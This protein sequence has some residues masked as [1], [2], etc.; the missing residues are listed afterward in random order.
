MTKNLYYEYRKWNFFWGFFLDQQNEV[1]SVMEEFN[2]KGW[3]VRDFEWGSFPKLTLLQLIKVIIVTIITLGF[4]SYWVGFSI[5][6]ESTNVNPNEKMTSTNAQQYN[7]GNGDSTSILNEMKSFGIINE[8]EYNE[9]INS[10]EINKKLNKHLNSI[11]DILNRAKTQGVLS[12]SDYNEKMNKIVSEE[13]AKLK[14]WQKIKPVISDIPPDIINQLPLHLKEQL[15]Q[16]IGEFS[17]YYF[18][19]K[20]VLVQSKNKLQFIERDRWDSIIKEGKDS[21]YNLLY[22]KK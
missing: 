1:Q 15:E 13:T 5:I 21:N 17:D 20:N 3:W 8:T 11:M 6:F 9:K 12:L 22:L 7:N 2:A 4:C 10:L 14:E 19:C 16:K 18:A